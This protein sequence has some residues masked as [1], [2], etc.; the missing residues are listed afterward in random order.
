[1][2]LL[3]FSLECCQVR[4]EDPVDFVVR[5]L[6]VYRFKKIILFIFFVLG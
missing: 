5:I 2:P 4:P 1:L 6:I 3:F